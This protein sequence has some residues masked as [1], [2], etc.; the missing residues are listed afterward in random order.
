[1]HFSLDGYD[2]EGTKATLPK[3]MKMDTP[4]QANKRGKNSKGKTLNK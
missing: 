1:M 2:E 3:G 4:A